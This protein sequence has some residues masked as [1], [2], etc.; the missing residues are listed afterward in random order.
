MSFLNKKFDLDDPNILS[1]IDDLSL[2]SAPFGLKLLDVVNFNKNMNVL[3]IGSGL[4]FPAIEL[5]QRLGNSS[6]IFAIDPWTAANDRFRL[7]I[8]AMRIKNVK[9]IE[10]MAEKLPFEHEFFNL[11]VSNNGIN[12]VENDKRVF[13]EIKRVS[14]KGTQL[15]FTFNLADS[16]IEFYQVYE[17][18]LKELH[19]TEEIERLKKHIYSKRKPLDYFKNLINEA[20]F[21]IVKIYHDSFNLRF[22]DGST[23]LNHFLIQI[24]F[25]ENWIHV[26]DESDIEP[27]FQKLEMKLNNISRDKGELRLTIPWVC[28]DCQRQS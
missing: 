11:I 12:N 7:K 25:L 23:M 28:V 15:V 3:D 21:Q 24:G 6:K 10:G 19:K 4:G 13:E 9:I 20:D 5:S 14:T 17:K 8:E 22:L 26:L 27:V 2:W 1:V 18:I 16:M